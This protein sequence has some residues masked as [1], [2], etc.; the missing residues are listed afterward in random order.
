MPFWE[1]PTPALADRWSAIIFRDN[2]CIMARKEM[3]TCEGIA[4]GADQD[5]DAFLH[6]WTEERI[7]PVEDFLDERD[8]KYLAERRSIE[9]IQLA[10]KKGFRNELAEK[11]KSYGSV[12]Q[13]VT[14]LFGRANFNARSN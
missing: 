8:Q 11:V 7:W 14:N 12:L 4:V 6:E 10:Q 9:L 1:L 3:I 5:F 2:Q 13:Y